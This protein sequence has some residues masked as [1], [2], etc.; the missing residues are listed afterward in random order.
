M[1]WVVKITLSP[2]C[3]VGGGEGGGWEALVAAVY[4]AL[5][6]TQGPSGW[7]WREELF[8]PSSNPEP[9]TESTRMRNRDAQYSLS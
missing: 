9:T 3:R 5:G 8:H 1:I 2:R 6:G 4:K 7:E